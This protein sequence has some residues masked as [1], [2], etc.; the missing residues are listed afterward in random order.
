MHS[1]SDKEKAR[2]AGFKLINLGVDLLSF[3]A[4]AWVKNILAL[5]LGS[6]WRLWSPKPE[7]LYHVDVS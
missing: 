7:W 3:C 4:V 5:D 2:E 1:E 6:T